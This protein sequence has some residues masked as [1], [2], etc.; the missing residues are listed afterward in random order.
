MLRRI[1]AYAQKLM[2]LSGRLKQ[3]RD[4]RK[5]PRIAT[6]TVVQ[7]VLAMML[8]RLGSLNAL[9]QTSR[10]GFW[11][12]LL[13]TGLPSADTIA[14]VCTTMEAGPI[15]LMQHDLY[16]R[17]KRI[18][19]LEAPGHGLMVAVL[20][21]HETHATRRQKCSACLQRTVHTRNG[22]RAEY[23]HRL[24]HMNLV[25]RERCFQLDAEPILPGEDE[26][27]AALRLFDRVLQSHPRAFDVVAGDGLYARSDFFN[28]VRSK[29][30]HPLA[31]LKDENRDLL[32]DARGLWEQAT[33]KL[34][35]LDGVHYQLWDDQ[36]Y[37]TWPQCRYP[38]RVVRSLE[39]TQVKRQLDKQVEEKTVEWAWV[40]TLPSASASTMAMV[41]MGHSRW[42]IENKSFNEM[43][44][45][46]HGDH[47]YT[48]DGQAMLVLWLLL[49]LSVNLFMAF[50][51]R[52]LKPALRDFYDTLAIAR[53]M[54]GELCASLPIHQQGP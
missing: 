24:V 9:E 16:A 52:N 6:D 43:G 14:E 38:V 22:D 2:D 28:H 15:R 23:Y 20:D 45:R 17:L 42:S 35:D 7:S 27:A 51:H 26:V 30:K 3:M 18:K 13:G 11:K 33:P 49:S 34:K 53:Q 40:T 4:G 29:G 31:V 19:A 21:G 48:H 5:R 50:Y 36:G 44:T 1:F 47:V 37:T 10:G 46:W 12:K 8:A 25:G 41:K 54:L 39:T 32:K